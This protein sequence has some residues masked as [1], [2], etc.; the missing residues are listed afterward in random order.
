MQC[1]RHRGSGTRRGECSKRRRHRPD[2]GEPRV[3]AFVRFCN[4]HGDARHSLDGRGI[5]S[6]EIRSSCTR[7]D[8]EF[9]EVRWDGQS[10]FSMSASFRYRRNDLNER[11]LRFSTCEY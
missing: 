10:R 4:A 5:T 11:D 1:A 7:S 3:R 9:E 8:P 6:V 2:A